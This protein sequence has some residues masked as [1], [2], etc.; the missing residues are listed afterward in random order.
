MVL[1]IAMSDEQPHTMGADVKVDMGKPDSAVHS[2]PPA[3]A[4]TPILFFVIGGILAVCAV[5]GIIVVI[6]YT[7]GQ[8][9]SSTDPVECNL[10]KPSTIRRDPSGSNKRSS[11]TT[12]DTGKGTVW[13][14]M[15]SW[16]PKTKPMPAPAGTKLTVGMYMWSNSMSMTD[17]TFKSTTGTSIRRGTS[18][19]ERRA[20][21]KGEQDCLNALN[22]EGQLP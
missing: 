15:R 18:H 12:I 10:P 9:D 3:K 7:V 4:G 17:T 8:S 13:Y 2:E 22:L 21:L 6:V 16:T 19:S 14:T 1:G 20:V 5:A 11:S